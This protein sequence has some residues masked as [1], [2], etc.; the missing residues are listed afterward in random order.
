MYCLESADLPGKNIFD[1]VI[2]ANTQWKLVPATIAGGKMMAL[3]GQAK[4]LQG[5]GL[6]QS[7]IPGI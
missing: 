4:I 1:V 5:S 7:F 6:E 3:T 2:P